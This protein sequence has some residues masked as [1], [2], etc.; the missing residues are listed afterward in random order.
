MFRASALGGVGHGFGV[1]EG[2]AFAVGVEGA[3]F[4]VGDGGGFLCRAG[5][6]EEVVGVEVHA[7][8]AAIELGHSGGDQ[9]AQGGFHGEPA[10]LEQAEQEEHAAEMGGEPSPEPGRGEGSAVLAFLAAKEPTE[11]PGI[12]GEGFRLDVGHRF[13]G[14]R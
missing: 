7:E 9:A 6:L 12:S 5:G 1:L 10:T 4:P 3:V 13:R 11:V 14:R 2:G 8:G